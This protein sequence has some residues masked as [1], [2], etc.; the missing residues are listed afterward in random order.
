ML[1]PRGDSAELRPQEALQADLHP[2]CI[3][4][5]LQSLVSLNIRS[6]EAHSQHFSAEPHF[7]GGSRGCLSINIRDPIF[8]TV[9][10]VLR[11]EPQHV[12]RAR[13]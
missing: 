9:F 11:A 1:Y 2:L 12:T 7:R 3:A 4:A 10:P 13:R 6:L 8:E 5:E